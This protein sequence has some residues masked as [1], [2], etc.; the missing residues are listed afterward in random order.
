MKSVAGLLASICFL[1]LIPAALA[2]ELIFGGGAEI[3]VHFS[4]AAGSGLLAL[5]AF[6]FG[7]P[8]YLAFAGASVAGSLSIIFL[9]QAIG[10]ISANATLSYI[11]IDLLG[12]RPER[13]LTD[14]LLIWFDCILM[15]DG[16][17]KS[18]I[19]GVVTI[20]AAIA[21]EIYAYWLNCY[22]SSLDAEFAGLKVVMLAPFIWLLVESLKSRRPDHRAESTL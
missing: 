11:A 17:G 12:Q 1:T 4:L 16:E 9:M 18:R 19:L 10:F 14:A 6:G 7:A 15:I 8:R 3:S 2:V 13:L 22:G 5:A 21:V 20:A